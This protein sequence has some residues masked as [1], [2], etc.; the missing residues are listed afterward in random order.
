MIVLSRIPK[1][2]PKLNNG[3][4]SFLGGSSGPIGG[5]NHG[6]R[7]AVPGLNPFAGEFK[8]PSEFLAPIPH[9]VF[10]SLLFNSEELIL[11]DLESFLNLTEPKSLPRKP[12]FRTESL[13]GFLDFSVLSGLHSSRTISWSR[14]TRFRSLAMFM[15]PFWH[16]GCALLAH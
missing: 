8:I 9:K 1:T 16:M 5:L 14:A 12:K 15:S 11:T 2:I 10:P 3:V 6:S 13:D 4:N 7:L